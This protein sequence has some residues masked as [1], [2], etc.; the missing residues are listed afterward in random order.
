MGNACFN[1]GAAFYAAAKADDLK[2]CESLITD[3]GIAEWF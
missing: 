1:V 3:T 2:L